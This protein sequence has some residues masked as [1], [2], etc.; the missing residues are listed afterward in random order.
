M[1]SSGVRLITL[2]AVTVA[3]AGTPQPVSAD[4]L[5]VYSL[6]IQSINTNTGT[7]T[8]GDQS[9]V[10]D[11]GGLLLPGDS[12]E[13]AVPDRA[14]ATDQFDAANIYVDSS[15]NGAEFRILAWIRE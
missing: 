9:G 3:T 8:F 12:V 13:I 1:A 7:Q 6:V 10:T 15:S 2:P 5:F 4:S 14:K 11:D